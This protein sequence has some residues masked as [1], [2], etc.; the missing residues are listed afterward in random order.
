MFCAL[1]NMISADADDDNEFGSAFVRF[2]RALARFDNC[3]IFAY[4]GE[5]SPLALFDT[6]TPP[7]YRVHVTLYQAGPYMLDPFFH[8]ASQRRLGFWRMREL[9][10]DHFYRSEYFRSYYFETGLAEEVGF[11][12]AIDPATVVVLSL[13]RLKT[14]GAFSKPEAAMLRA[15]EPIVR[16]VINGRWRKVGNRFAAAVG[17]PRDFKLPR[18]VRPIGLMAWRSLGLTEREA[19]IVDLVLQGHSSDSIAARLTIA[20]GTVKVH[21]RNVYRK[22]V[23]SSQAELLAIYIDRIVGRIAAS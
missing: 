7:Q 18:P 21:R 16:T 10:P 15:C 5:A 9:A 13:M 22:L 2:L 1:A 23:I 11:F 8:A 17:A 14:S 3:V 6:F 20:P 12:V 4:C 19:S